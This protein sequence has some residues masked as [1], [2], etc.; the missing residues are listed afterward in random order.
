MEQ[1]PREVVVPI[2]A[3]TLGPAI[4]PAA[5]FPAYAVIGAGGEVY[6]AA[7]NPGRDGYL[8]LGIAAVALLVAW[9]VGQ[10][11][12][13]LGRS[14]TVT[15]GGEGLRVEYNALLDD[16]WHVPLANIESVRCVREWKLKV[17]E[18]LGLSGRPNVAVQLHLPSSRVPVRGRYFLAA[19]LVR[20]LVMPNTTVSSFVFR[21][22]VRD[23]EALE[24]EIGMALEHLES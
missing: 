8:G 23:L 22:S 13:L 21:T 18:Q 24:R 11:L 15:F 19:L 4:L 2:A 9:C 16:V 20:R 6:D 10:P 7:T 17:E 14:G 3:Q 12:R 5:I 1:P